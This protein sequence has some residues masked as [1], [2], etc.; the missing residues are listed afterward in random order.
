MNSGC[1]WRSL[2]VEC[3]IDPAVRFIPDKVICASVFTQ[4]HGLPTQ[5]SVNTAEGFKHESAIPCAVLMSLEKTRLT[6]YVG[7]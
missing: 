1:S 2:R 5:V 3:P 6:D 4:R 7:H